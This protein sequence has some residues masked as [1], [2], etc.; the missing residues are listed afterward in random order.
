[1]Y[2][3]FKYENIWRYSKK[4]TSLMYIVHFLDKNNIKKPISQPVHSIQSHVPR[5]TLTCEDQWSTKM[6]MFPLYTSTPRELTAVADTNTER[7]QMPHEYVH[8]CTYKS[9]V[10]CYTMVPL[11]TRRLILKRNTVLRF[12]FFI[13]ISDILVK[14]NKSYFITQ[15]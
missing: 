7:Y 10:L 6:C 14:A 2:N 4:Q 12:F 13:I 11:Y 8:S 3:I 1:M 9:I 5:C 15:D